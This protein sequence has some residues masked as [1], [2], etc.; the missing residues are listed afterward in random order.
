MCQSI[1]ISKIPLPAAH[2]LW[3]CATPA[4]A[5]VL[6]E[7][8]E[9]CW[10]LL[11]ALTPWPLLYGAPKFIKSGSFTVSNYLCKRLWPNHSCFSQEPR[12]DHLFTLPTSLWITC[13]RNTL[14]GSQAPNPNQRSKLDGFLV[15]T[16]P[17][18]LIICGEVVI[19]CWT[20]SWH[21]TMSPL[22]LKDASYLVPQQVF[23]VSTFLLHHIAAFLFI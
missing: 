17:V 6:L 23:G 19:I 9:R 7:S 14:E 1:S 10:V 20:A 18:N 16:G 11:C 22:R 12:T 15:L 13:S 5:G 3:V 8:T 21:I 4:S 2:S